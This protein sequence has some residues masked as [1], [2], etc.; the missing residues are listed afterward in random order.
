[1]E[2]T[3]KRPPRRKSLKKLSLISCIV[4]K[5]DAT[6]TKSS[7]SRPFLLNRK[8]CLNETLFFAENWRE[9]S[10]D[11]V[12]FGQGAGGAVLTNRI[13]RQQHK[14]QPSAYLAFLAFLVPYCR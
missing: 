9:C 6:D 11:A 8:L 12:W 4:T 2:Q 5:K 13:L 7:L 10:L 3:E 14:L 1:M